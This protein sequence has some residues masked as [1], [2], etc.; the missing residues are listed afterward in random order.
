[1]RAG[2]IHEGNAEALAFALMGIGH[3]LAL[4]WLIWPG[5]DNERRRA[6]GAS[7]LSLQVD[8][9]PEEAFETIADFISRGLAPTYHV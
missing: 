2:E 5:N 6:S 4:R 1:M 8:S 9:V 3:F 7:P